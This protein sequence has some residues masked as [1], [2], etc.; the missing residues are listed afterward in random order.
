M[1]EKRLLNSSLLRS[2][3]DMCYCRL[4]LPQWA[5]SMLLTSYSSDK[6]TV[7]HEPSLFR[8]LTVIC[9]TLCRNIEC[10]CW[11]S[12]LG[13]QR[14]TW[15]YPKNNDTTCSCWNLCCFITREN[16]HLQGDNENSNICHRYACQWVSTPLSLTTTF[17]WWSSRELRDHLWTPCRYASLL[18]LCYKPASLIINY[19][20][21]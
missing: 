1:L 7:C 2:F 5:F 8:N 14:H 18:V 17:S 10:T 21:R 13:M 11:P 16:L 15:T 9:A 3:A 19:H 20:Q 6:A 12:V 4:H